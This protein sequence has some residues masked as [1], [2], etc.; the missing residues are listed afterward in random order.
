MQDGACREHG[1]QKG[2]EDLRLMLVMDNGLSNATLIL[3]KDVAESFLEQSFD[4]IRDAIQS[5]GSD[6][7]IAELRAK[8]V[9]KRF[10]FTGRAMIDTQGALLMADTFVPAEEDPKEMSDIVRQRW[11][12]FA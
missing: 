4:Q 9:G 7:F 8:V 3:S 6:S 11:E 1:A 2:V 10:T 12:V 5:N